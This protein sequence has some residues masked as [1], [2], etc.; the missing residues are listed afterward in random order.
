MPFATLA[1]GKLHFLDRGTGKP[2]VFIHGLGA[3]L[4]F[5]DPQINFFS[6]THRVICPELRGNARSSK[7]NV[8]I[9][10]ILDTQCSDVAALIEKLGIDQVVLAGTSY[11]GAFCFN[12]VLRYPEKVSGLVVAD[13]LGDTKISSAREAFLVLLHYCGL[14]G[15]YLPKPLLTFLIKREYK[16]WPLTQRHMVDF[17]QGMR[18][19]EFLLQL[20]AMNRINFTPYLKQVNCPVLG[21]VGDQNKV[22][23]RWMKSAMKEIPQSSLE[24]VSHSF[25]PTNLC[26]PKQYNHLV[27]EFLEK[28]DHI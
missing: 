22:G 1:N 23:V 4:S 13:T 8:P 5:Y 21:I 14:W 25:D 20:L 18:R 27:K 9:S 6:K 10:K 26:Q 17:V 19:T 24:I 2:L 28:L 7:L 12:F 15:L 3:N 16:Q 11:G